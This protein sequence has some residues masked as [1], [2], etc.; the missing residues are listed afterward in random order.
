MRFFFRRSSAEAEPSA[1]PPDEHA[2]GVIVAELPAPAEE[3]RPDDLPRAEESPRAQEAPRLVA[4]APRNELVHAS[5][6]PSA[7]SKLAQ[8]FAD[9]SPT[10]EDHPFNRISQPKTV[11]KT[12]TEPLSAPEKSAIAITIAEQDQPLEILAELAK[13][14][15]QQ[16]LPVTSAGE[17]F[18]G[19]GVPPAHFSAIEAAT[20]ASPAAAE[21][22]FH[23]TQTQPPPAQVRGTPPDISQDISQ[24]I[25][26]VAARKQTREV[27][28]ELCPEDA[29]TVLA[30]ASEELT[31]EE[32][33]A[34]RASKSDA[35]A[36]E[37]SASGIAAEI[38]HASSNWAFEE[39]LASHREWIDSKG[40]HGKKAD[41][42]NA[43][44]DG[45]ELINVNLRLADLHYANLKSADLLLADLR[46]ACMVRAD[47]EEACLVGAN[48]E[49][50][51]L[52]GA[53]L[54]T[55]LGLVPR[56]LAGAN[57]REASLPA[58]ISQFPA[59]AIFRAASRGAVRFF[60]AIMTLSA[61]SAIAIWKTKDIQ[62]VTDSAILPFLHS[63]KASAAM[64]TAE[65][66]LIT[67][68]V[69]FLLYLAFLAQVQRVWSAALE[70]PAVFPD[71]SSLGEKESGIIL[72]LLRAHFRWMNQ[73]APSSR[74]LETTLSLLLAYW[75][76]PVMLFLF[77]ARYLTLQ[78]IHGTVLHELLASVAA[79][80][81][82]H[83]TFKVGRPQEKWALQR[84]F[85]ARM[86]ERLRGSKPPVLVGILLAIATFISFGTIAGVPHDASRASQYGV[87]NIR[88]WAPTALW[89]VGYDPYA[90]LTE[91]AISVAPAGWNGSD[92][93]V[94]SVRG[95][96]LN[97]PRFRYAQAYGV[98][99]ANAHLWRA[100]FRGAYLSNSDLRAADLTQ[101]NFQFAILDGAR[102]NHANLDRATLQGGHFA[103]TDFRD[104]NLSYATLADSFLMDARFDGASLYDALLSNSTLVR[105][106]FDRADLRNTHIDAANL[107]H[108]D[109]RQAYLWSASI[110]NS[111]L[112]DA[113]LGSAILIG[114]TLRGSNL[115]G[116]HFAQT[117]LNETD[118]TGTILDG[119]DMRGAF[120]LTAYQV[121]LARSHAG[122]L[123]DDTLQTQIDAQCPTAH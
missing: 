30:A 117:V 49:G 83:A 54:E 21:P 41:L 90:D 96:R 5:A 44:L 10:G 109:L 95:I 122:A 93:Q 18:R 97:T 13:E 87:A 89:T 76:V 6:L 25:S 68:V 116:A 120:S 80:V 92:D 20:N 7:A 33:P 88:R 77:W 32:S 110:Q 1:V 61:I 48:L 22:P 55:A 52:E 100:D 119:A 94:G 4:F 121:C 64:P 84:T 38:P 101:S 72:G 74:T 114:A 17:D 29:A 115:G 60:T 104:A 19:S 65:I 23:Q 14:A 118:L 11:G 46:D 40:L 66:F 67:P 16:T 112:K 102:L 26:T 43:Q 71:G 36:G 53:S 70:L 103:R 99:L 50:A 69:L 3:P 79:G 34:P 86:S 2:A 39:T 106:T 113:D 85:A 111:D 12:A 81:A 28:G 51:N 107:E 78:E 31:A 9:E 56:Q 105:A 37:E 42:A 59:T 27:G 24:E 62:L 58:Q 15:E 75:T 73:D 57:L 123:F 82:L 45:V 8:L 98:F 35:K 108:A 63:A 47:L 91:A